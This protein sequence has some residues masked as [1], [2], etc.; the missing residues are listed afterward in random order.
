MLPVFW[1]GM[2]FVLCM[3]HIGGQENSSNEIGEEDGFIGG[4]N[5]E[6]ALT[7]MCNSVSDV[8]M[9]LFYF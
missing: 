3:Q 5:G 4:E 2:F 9:H 7:C 1:Y 8:H 6:V